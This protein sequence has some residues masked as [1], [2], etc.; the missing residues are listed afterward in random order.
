MVDKRTTTTSA[1]RVTGGALT[2]DLAQHRAGITTEYVYWCGLF[3]SAP[4]EHL[5]IRGVGFS[6]INEKILK[7][8]AN[9]QQRRIPVAGT[10]S[11]LT[12]DA[13]EEFTERL[14]RTVFRFTPTGTRH[15]KHMVEPSTL[16]DMDEDFPLCV[17]GHVITIPTDEYVKQRLAAGLPSNAY[18]QH[19]D[20]EPAAQH[21]Y[22]VL[23]EDQQNPQRGA[24]FPEPLSVTGL[25]WPDTSPV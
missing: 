13:F 22:M 17:P 8:G 6:K 4:V 3:P 2:P 23:C 7:G 15:E 16:I 12:R 21:M 9:R 19:K 20:D 1:R 5:A 25:T 11:R 18:T 14:K 10:L 24:Y